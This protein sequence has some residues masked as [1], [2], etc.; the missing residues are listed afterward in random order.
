M[1]EAR[2]YENVSEVVQRLPLGLVL[3]AL[4]LGSFCGV[5]GVL[6]RKALMNGRRLF[7][8]LRLPLPI[9]MAIGGLIVGAVGIFMPEAWGNG[10]EVIRV[11]VDNAAG[12]A[13]SLSLILTLF[14]WKQIATIVTVGAGGLGGI[15]TP[16][17]L[18][19]SPSPRDS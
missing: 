5:G 6:F 17:L 18:Y 10:F 14:F 13:P 9:V 16:C 12:T 1:T 4:V 19:T 7:G 11:V 8:S 3:A 2:V 15:F